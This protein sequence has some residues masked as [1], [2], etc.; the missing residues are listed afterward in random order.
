MVKVFQEHEEKVDSLF[1]DDYAAWKGFYVKAKSKNF[2]GKVTIRGEEP[3]LSAKFE[4]K[5]KLQD[6]DVEGSVNLTSSGNHTIEGEWDLGNVV[7]K[8]KLT[9]TTNWNSATHGHDTIVSVQNKSI[10]DLKAKFDFT[11]FKGGDWTL[12]NHFGKKFTKQLSLGL[13]FTWDGKKSEITS[14]NIGLL[15]KPQPWWRSWVTYALRGPIGK[16]TDWTKDATL[17]L[18]QR[19]L[20]EASTKLGFDYVYDL[21]AQTS[22][23]KLGIETT[24]VVGMLVKSKVDANGHLEASAKMAL[25][26]HWNLII[27]TATTSENLTGKQEARFGFGLEGNL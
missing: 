24:P 14:T 8:T 7:D 13:D 15:L 1:E 23:L 17:T 11:Y 21:K 25:D 16:N 4:E 19:F 26:S 27:S 20:A 10:E 12:T 18:K 6:F 5:G 2:V 9:H 22:G 3:E